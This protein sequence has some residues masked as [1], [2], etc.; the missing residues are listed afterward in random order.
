MIIKNSH[1]IDREE[2]IPDKT[3]PGKLRKHF[4]DD[5]IEHLLVIH[6]LTHT[7]ISVILMLMFIEQIKH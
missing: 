4:P 6:S 2:F 7:R 1:N 3:I 5:Y